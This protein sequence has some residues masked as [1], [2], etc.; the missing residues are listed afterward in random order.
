MQV[1]FLKDV[2]NV[3]K[4]GEVK[5]VKGGYA[6]NYLIPQGLATIAT[7]ET[8]KQAE[9]REEKEKESQRELEN[10]FEEI[11]NVT[12]KKPLVFKVKAGEKGGVFEAVS[13]KDISEKL[14]AAFPKLKGAEVKIKTD[15]VRELGQK[16]IEVSLGQ[17]IGGE[18]TIEI[19]PKQP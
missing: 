14:V 10:H 1:I 13:K 3:G 8:V 6:R 4:K 16:K 9:T 15:H 11:Q 12:A 5:T 18:I 7:P 19:Q 2:K 17:G